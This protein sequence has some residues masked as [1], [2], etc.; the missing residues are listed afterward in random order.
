MLCVIRALQECNCVEATVFM[1]DRVPPHIGRQV[2]CL[3]RETFTEEHII[4]ESFPNPWRARSPDL[5]PCNVWLW[6]YLKDRVYQGH[7]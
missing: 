4:S 2:Q 1:Q 5:N 6:G 7:V 3:L